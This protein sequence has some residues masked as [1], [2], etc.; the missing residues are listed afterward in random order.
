MRT[1][2]HSLFMRI[3]EPR[4][5]R[6]LQFV[7]YIVMGLFGISALTQP[8]SRFEAILNVYLVYSFGGFITLGALLGAVAVLPGIWWLERAG[9]ISLTTGMA[10]YAVV[11]TALGYSVVGVLIAVVLGLTFAQRW[12][13]IRSF[14]LAPREPKEE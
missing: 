11:A 8:P 10:M 9:L 12:L 2:A 3:A 7:I 4:V 1:F 6:I 5:I 14:Q 13:E